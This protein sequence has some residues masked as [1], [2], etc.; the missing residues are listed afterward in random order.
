MTVYSDRQFQTWSFGSVNIRSGKQKDEGANIYSLYHESDLE[1]EVGSLLPT[2][3]E[4]PQFG[5]E[6]NP[7]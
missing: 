7:T 5:N 6:I 1:S 2:G 4:V 3:S